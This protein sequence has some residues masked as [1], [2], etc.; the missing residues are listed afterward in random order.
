MTITVVSNTR[1]GSIVMKI[2]GVEITRSGHD[3]WIRSLALAVTVV[4]KSLE[5]P[6]TLEHNRVAAAGSHTGDETEVRWRGALAVLVVTKAR[7]SAVCLEHDGVPRFITKP[8]Q[9]ARSATGDDAKI[10]RKRGFTK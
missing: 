7:K 5:I 4:T 10:R 1:D 3:A 2:D 9:P 8:A 6:I